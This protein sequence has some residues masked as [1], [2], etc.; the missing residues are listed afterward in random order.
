MAGRNDCTIA[1]ALESMARA[2]H[3]QQNQAG[4]E[5]CGLGKTGHHAVDCRSDMPICYNC[6]KYGHIS[7]NCQSPRKHSLKGSIP[8]IS[9]I[10]TGVRH[11]FVSLDCVERLGLKLSSMDDLVCLHL[12]NLD[13]IL[14]MNWLEFNHVHINYFDKTKSFPKFDASNELFVSSKKVNEFVSDDA[15]MFMILASMKAE[16]KVVISEFP[17]VS[18]FSEVFPDHIRQSPPEREVEFTI[19]LV[20]GTRSVLTDPYIMYT[21][22]LSELNMQLEDLLENKFF[23]LSVSPWGAPVLLVKKK[24]GYHRIHVKHEDILKTAFRTRYGH[25]E[26]SVM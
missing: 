24:D 11:L 19:D 3:I 7:T 10:D 2:L 12:K 16:S 9:N 8:L 4:D 5:F 22:E 14:G 23:R 26:Y 6:G 21:S 13:S 17:V 18:D 20:L 15:I 25:Y 1:N